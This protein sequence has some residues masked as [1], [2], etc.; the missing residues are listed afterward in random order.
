VQNHPGS[1][2]AA[3]AGDLAS[4]VDDPRCGVGLSPDHCVDMDE[5]VLAVT[6]TI[7]PWV[8]Q[9]HLAD[10]ERLAEGGLKACLPGQGI[11]PNRE[12]V[13]LL[14]Q[15][16]FEGWVSFKWEKP[17]Y[18]DLPDAGVALPHFAGFMSRAAP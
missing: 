12:V 18:P 4:M 13:D 1:I 11:V 7:A 16:G 2:S 9:L 6:A 10:R 14:V 3:Q 8:G 15:R 5:D 17:T